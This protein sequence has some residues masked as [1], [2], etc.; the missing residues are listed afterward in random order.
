MP[1]TLTRW[2]AASIALNQFLTRTLHW[3]PLLDDLDLFML[4]IVGRNQYA[5]G[6]DTIGIAAESTGDVDLWNPQR[7]KVDNSNSQ[8]S[9]FTDANGGVLV[10][11][12]RFDVRVSNSAIS[13]TPKV[14]YGSTIAT[15]TSVAS[16]SGQAACSATNTDS[17]GTNQYQEVAITLPPGVNFL[18]PLLTVSGTP[19]VGYQVWGRVLFDCFI[20]T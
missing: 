20:Q 11:Q 16:L 2:S 15:M 9:N 13:V 18:R 19:A 4:G 17:T 8:I 12:L 3:A 14:Q 6:S 7:L 10:V 1:R 5:G